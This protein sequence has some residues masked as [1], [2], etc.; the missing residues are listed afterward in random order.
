MASAWQSL[1]GPSA[2]RASPRGRGCAPVLSHNVDAFDRQDA[3]DE[4]RAGRP[5]RFRDRVEAMV[6]AVDEVD[7]GDARRAVHDRAAW[8]APIRVRGFVIRPAVRFG[9]VDDA[10][11]DAVAQH[12]HEVLPK[13]GAGDGD[14]I[15]F[16]EARGRG[17]LGAEGSAL[18]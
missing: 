12:A 7:V 9:F 4:D 5:F 17:T 2:S 6:C 16:V 10:P 1:P 15:A 8:G 14:G 3:A 11:Q 13:Q 18:A